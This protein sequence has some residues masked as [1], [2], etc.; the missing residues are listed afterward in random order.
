MSAAAQDSTPARPAASW[1]QPIRLEEMLLL[2]Q[3]ERDRR[4]IMRRMLIEEGA[5]AGPIDDRTQLVWRKIEDMLA[6]G[7]VVRAELAKLL[8]TVTIAERGESLR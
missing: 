8:D 4:A 7:I 1:P 3:A 2:V 6:K 5:L